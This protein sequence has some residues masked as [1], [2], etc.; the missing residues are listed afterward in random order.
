MAPTPAE[1]QVTDRNR[2][3]LA[4]L[5]TAIVVAVISGRNL[6]DLQRVVGVPGLVYVGVHGVAW[7]VEGREELDADAEPYRAL[8]EQ[9]T[10]ELRDLWKLP[11]VVGE[12]KSVGLTFHYRLAAD[13]PVTREA[14]L[15]AVSASAAASRFRVQEGILL[16]ELRPPIATGK[17]I[18]VR[19]LAERFGLRSLVFLGDDITDIDGFL[20][21]RRLRESNMVAAYGVAVAHREAPPA[22]A[23]AADFTVDDVSRVEWLLGEIA[24]AYGVTV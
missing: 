9:A 10:R 4:A 20:E 14:I 18:A 8:T 11:G 15:R 16:I 23:E 6:A 13:Q 17:G 2:A 1:A 24:T 5:R 3:L 19:R 22:A 21:A 7:L 12:V